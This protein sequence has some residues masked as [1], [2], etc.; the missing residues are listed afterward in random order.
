MSE[1]EQ[2]L[3]A[4]VGIGTGVVGL[5]VN[6]ILVIIK[7]IAGFIAGSVSILADAMNSL[8]DSAGALLTIGG[9]Y[10]ANK[11]PDRE[12]PYGHQR[13]E[14][15]SGLFTAIIILIVGFQF[16]ISSIQKILN[17]TSVQSSQLVLILLIASIIIKAGLGVYYYQKNKR[18]TDFSKAIETLTK[19]SFYDTLMNLVI[20]IS[21]ILEIQFNWYIDG[22]IGVLVA[23]I[24]LY[25][26]IT[27]IIET[28]NDLLG[29]RPNP[30]LVDEMQNVLDSYSK[31]VGYHDLILH[32]YGP[33]KIFATV[34]IEIDASWGLVEAHRVIDSI[35]KEFN[36]KFGI[37]LVGHLDPVELDDDEQNNIYAYIKQTLKSYDE[38]F[39][40]HDLRI[41]NQSEKSEIFFDVTVP[42]E[43]T[44]S[45]E[46]LYQRITEDLSEKLSAYKIRIHF[47]RDYFLKE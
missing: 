17:P 16:L 22:Y 31:L 36:E 11:P 14:Y 24:I 37:R 25:G 46:K 6:L 1:N 42:D 41:E 45:D 29:T 33:N 43:V 2:N 26:G 3:R 9:F 28:S 27:S 12:H 30:K 20:I 44:A 47:D 10:V 5:V 7:L 32:K 38:N 13:A 23:L 19:D 18:M 39:H 34:D 35:E 15:I 40:F 4:R 8:G 21:Y